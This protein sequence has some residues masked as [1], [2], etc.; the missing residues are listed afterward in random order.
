VADL[1]SLRVATEDVEIAGQLIRAGEGIIP[2]VAAANHDERA[3]ACPHAFDPART[4]R[5]HVAFGYGVHQCLGQ[6]LV[7]IEMETAYR[8]LF[9]RIPGLRL[10]VPAEE[11][12]FKYDGV[13]CGLHALPVRW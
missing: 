7:R 4:E 13:L 8:R 11:L 5:H 6:N 10:A 2:L 3:F 12:P 1:V 9:E